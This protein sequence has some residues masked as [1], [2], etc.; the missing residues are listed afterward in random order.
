[1]SALFN[2]L[3]CDA[4][5]G[6]IKLFI[7]IVVL[8]FYC[9]RLHFVA[10]PTSLKARFSNQNITFAGWSLSGNMLALVRVVTFRLKGECLKKIIFLQR[11]SCLYYILYNIFSDHFHIILEFLETKETLFLIMLKQ[12]TKFI[13]FYSV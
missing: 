3:I 11:V 6:C 7:L 5:D 12:K 2:P 9:F 1:M 13:I 8:Y 4:V 10:F